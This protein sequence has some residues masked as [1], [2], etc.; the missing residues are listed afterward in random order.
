MR[1]CRRTGGLPAIKTHGCF[2]VFIWISRLAVKDSEVPRSNLRIRDKQKATL[3]LRNSKTRSCMERQVWDLSKASHSI[4]QKQEVLL[5]EPV[6][7]HVYDLTGSFH[8]PVLN[9][10][11]RHSGR[12]LL[13]DACGSTQG[14]QSTAWVHSSL[15]S[16][17]ATWSRQDKKGRI[18]SQQSTLLRPSGTSS[19]RV[20][21]YA[22]T[23]SSAQPILPML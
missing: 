21:V 5:G 10:V 3:P 14:P 23:L 20:Y 13:V 4:F 9:S 19:M 18:A 6:W 15:R 17:A 22:S 11:F 8:L 2:I 7:L 12:V 1:L 16:H